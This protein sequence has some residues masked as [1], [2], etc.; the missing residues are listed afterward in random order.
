MNTILN[1]NYS[2]LKP[3][4]ARVTRVCTSST[5]DRSEA[6][7]ESTY[8]VPLLRLSDD[9]YIIPETLRLLAKF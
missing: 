5:L 9:Q 8:V 2:K 6:T 1:S 3:T 4:P 7:L